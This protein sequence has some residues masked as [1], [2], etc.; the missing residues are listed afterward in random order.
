M[1]GTS[2]GWDVVGTNGVTV[3][4]VVGW[5][6]VGTM[7]GI[8]DGVS[9]GQA[10]Q[11]PQP[12]SNKLVT[13]CRGTQIVSSCII[14]CKQKVTPGPLLFPMGNS[15]GS[16]GSMVVASSLSIRQTS[17]TLVGDELGIDEGLVLGTPVGVILGLALGD[18]DG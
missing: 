6:V 14:N 12:K 10:P 7:V 4:D 8:L 9:V 1:V 3:G 5:R 15:Q 16:G 13:S 18:T 17:K 11:T 2:V